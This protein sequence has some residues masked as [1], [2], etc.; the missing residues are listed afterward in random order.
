MDV[1]DTMAE[2]QEN[3]DTEMNDEDLGIY[4]SGIF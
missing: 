4:K 3:V 1:G 2:V